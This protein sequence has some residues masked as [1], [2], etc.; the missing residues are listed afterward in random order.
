MEFQKMYF[1]LFNA[2]TDALAEIDAMNFGTAREL[3]RQAQIKS[4]EIY[5]GFDDKKQGGDVP[6]P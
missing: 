1:V 5:I 3:L 4:E 6:S 2:I